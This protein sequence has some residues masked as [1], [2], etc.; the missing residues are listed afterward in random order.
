M[1]VPRLKA[2][3]ADLER[4]SFVNLEHGDRG[5][6]IPDDLDKLAAALEAEPDTV[7][8]ILDPLVAFIPMRLDAHKDQ[9]ARGALT[10]LSRLA[11]RHGV[12][13]VA[14]MHLNKAAEAG[15]LFLRVS[16]SV[17]FMNAARSAFLVAEDPDD[18]DHRILAHGKNNLSEPGESLR[19]RIEGVTV[20]RNDGEPITTSRLVWMGTSER[21]VNDLLKSDHRDEPRNEAEKFLADLLADGPM[22]AGKVRSVAEE[23]GHAWRTVGRA[24]KALGITSFKSEFGGGWTWELPDDEEGHEEAQPPIGQD[25]AS[26]DDLEG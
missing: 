4:V 15:S 9:H 12:A 11:Q 14:V 7:L 24:K 5:F 13:I 26:F 23:A 21:G 6:V 16:S 3:G 8:V 18:R 22:T 25:V 1:V 19:F 2:A 10:P 20:E 17:G